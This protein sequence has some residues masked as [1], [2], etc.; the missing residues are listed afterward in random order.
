MASD[1]L[2]QPESRQALRRIL[3]LGY[4]NAIR[5]RYPT[6]AQYTLWD[7]TAGCWQRDAGF[8]IDHL[9][10]SPQAAHPPGLVAFRALGLK[11]CRFQGKRQSHVPRS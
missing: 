10:L 3:N 5:A 4:T 1:A 11:L 6:G 2:I 8:R 9:L 7:Y